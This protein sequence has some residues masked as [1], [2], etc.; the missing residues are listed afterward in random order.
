[1]SRVDLPFRDR[2]LPLDQRV[3]DL[4]ARLERTEKVNL[5]HGRF[6]SGGVERLGIPQLELADGPVGIRMMGIHPVRK[7]AGDDEVEDTGAANADGPPR[8]TA[9]PSTLLLAASWDTDAAW[10]YAALIGAEMLASNKHVLLGPGINL[11]RDPRG[12][13][14]FEYFGEDPFLTAEMAI[15]Y[16]RGL[17]DQRVGA[18]LK[19][20]VGNE[21]D[22]DR[23]YTSSEIDARTMREVYAYPFERA[24][25]EAHAWSVM[26]G[27]NLANGR[28]VAEHPAILKEL[29]RDAL[30]FDGVIL[31][32]WRAA[33]SA[34]PCV[35]ASLDMTTGFCSYVYGNG[36]EPLLEAGEVSEETLDAMARRILILYFRTGV[37]DQDREPGERATPRHTET[38]RELAA[39]G[40]VLLENRND[41]LPLPAAS[42]VLVTGPGATEA[43]VGTG[44]GLVNGGIGNV[45]PLAGLQEAYGSDPL[46]FFEDSSAI[47]ATRLEGTDL[48]VYV[49][50]AP[51]GGEGQDYSS[52][53]LEEGQEEEIL[54]LAELTDRLV[55][56]LQTGS[57]VDLNAWKGAPDALLVAWYGGQA[58]GHAIADL[59]TGRRNPSGK[60]PCTFGNAVSDY[61]AAR[62][63]EW[64]ARLILDRHPGK[65]GFKPEER[66]PI[67]ALQTACREG[68]FIG[69]RGFQR[70]GIEPCYP[71][72]FGRS[73]TRFELSG[74]E[75]V[76]PGNGW[77]VRL[78][79]RNVG[80]RAGAEVVQLYL[81]AP[82]GRV[83]RP[84]RELRGFCKVPLLPEQEGTASIPLQVRDLAF[85]DAER[86][87]WVAEAGTYR[88]HLG[89]SS[90]DLPLVL[91]LELPETTLL[92]HL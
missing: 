75:I 59:L 51:Q 12:G 46:D 90:R 70:E 82:A 81:E 24:I 40:M 91:D 86:A 58:T 69:Y 8:M 88:L 11:M 56:V 13:R 48:L 28:H 22:T 53:A 68:V 54:R 64:P 26:T 41:L 73:Y 35:E 1:M 9:L 65:P 52:L 15:A 4:L 76:S 16:V 71:F 42:R 19:H 27:N 23:H 25:R 84:A 92:P 47:D 79:V 72:G 32:D 66:K 49:A 43:E 83:E 10:R 67:L 61:P 57:S 44:S 37:I 36:L 5:T 30:G 6:L 62:L 3:E 60:L 63:G 34:G 45:S 74:P 7:S 31:T 78:V 14:N 2:S 39:A 85:F 50:R 77:E 80:A 55:V 21:P 38:A 18:N 33:Y 87:Q 29:L 20:Y 17:Q 89:T